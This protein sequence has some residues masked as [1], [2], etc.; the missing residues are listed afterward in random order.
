MRIEQL[1]YL[2]A[3]TEHGSLRRASEKLHL[4]QPALSEALT[5]LEREL[6]VTLLDRRRSGA[7]ISR[8]GRELLPYMSEVLAAVDR[9]RVAAGDR[10][11]ETRP[12]RVGTVHAAT[13]TLLVPALAAFT[14]HH[15]G[16]RVEVL[17]LPQPQ[18]DEGLAAGTLDLGL[19]D[20]LEGDDA[21]AGVEAT[22]L[23]H[24]R[25]VVV[26]PAAHP[27]GTR[28]QVGVEELRRERFVT[29]R[30]GSVMHRFVH[31]LFGADVP[32]A[33]HTTD[34]AEVAKALVAEGVGVT[35]LPDY[36]VHGDP[37]HRAGVVEV[38][39]I[40]GDDTVLALQVRERRTAQQRLSVHELR[41]AL[42][43]RAAEHRAAVTAA[44]PAS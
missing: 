12:V 3:V 38:R 32:V 14:R 37:L 11:D 15:D 17:T 42:V 6:R 26:L 9:L 33:A 18:I 35:V 39:P 25:P 19:L 22:V 10:R 31:R 21:P 30:T 16:S 43:A 4:S 1:E 34:T 7:Q 36:S 29:M 28:A 24:G 20:A 5:K 27:L 44:R 40:A 13:S 2:A 41:A 23:L 8:E